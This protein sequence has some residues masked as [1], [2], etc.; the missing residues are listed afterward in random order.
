MTSGIKRTQKAGRVSI[1]HIFWPLTDR[2]IL[3]DSYQLVKHFLD[4]P[5]WE[6]TIA[7]FKQKLLIKGMTRNQNKH[8]RNA[9]RENSNFSIYS[10]CPY[11]VCMNEEK[12]K[13]ILGNKIGIT[14]YF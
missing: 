1:P 2:N 4:F 12:V 11:Y 8:G 6:Y 3:D 7:S 10:D 13:K 9:P 14:I 5:L